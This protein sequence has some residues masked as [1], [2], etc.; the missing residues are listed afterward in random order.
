MN[1]G[2]WDR[3]KGLVRE[4]LVGIKCT[5]GSNDSEWREIMSTLRYYRRLGNIYVQ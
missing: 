1:T 5:G 4:V 2:T 3:I